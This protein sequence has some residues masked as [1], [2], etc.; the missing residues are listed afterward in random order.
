M[1]SDALILSTETS[2]PSARCSLAVADSTRKLVISSAI[3]SISTWAMRSRKRESSIS[4]RP[5]DIC[6]AAISL[7]FFSARLQM[8][9]PAL[10]LRSCVSRNFAYVRSEARVLDQRAAVRHLLRGD[11]LE[12]LQRPLANAHTGIAAAFVR[13][14]EF[15]VRQI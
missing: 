5:F 14:Q 1:I 2:G 11:L 3:S 6:S 10:P 9:T 4:G 12:L 15:R 8:P 7:S 13:E